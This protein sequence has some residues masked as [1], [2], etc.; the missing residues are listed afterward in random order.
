LAASYTLINDA[1]EEWDRANRGKP[2]TAYWLRDN[3]KGLLDPAGVQRWRDGEVV[4]RGY[5]RKQFEEAWRTHLAGIDD[6]FLSSGGPSPETSVTS[7]T[8]G[9]GFDKQGFFDDGLEETSGTSVTDRPTR[10]TISEISGL[11]DVTDVSDGVTYPF[12]E[13][14]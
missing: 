13:T 12:R 9:N 14:T 4:R 1:D 3:L 7:N 8:S 10:E 11:G 6:P 5:Y 2:I